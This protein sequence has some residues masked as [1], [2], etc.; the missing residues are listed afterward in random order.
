MPVYTPLEI[1]RSKA[2]I[3]LVKFNE[4]MNYSN[5]YYSNIQE[6]LWVSGR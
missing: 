5:N 4:D 3:I 1:N 2:K 6:K